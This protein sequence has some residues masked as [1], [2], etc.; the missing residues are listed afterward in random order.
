MYLNCHT[1]FS[2]RYG[3]MSP[4]ELAEQAVG[5]GAEALALTD[6][7]NTSAA[8]EFIRRCRSA[9]VKPV[10]GVEFRYRSRLNFIGLARNREGFRELNEYLSR[11]T[12]TPEL[13]PFGEHD[14][15]NC[16]VVYPFEET[17]I[18]PGR[19][20]D[21]EFVGVRPHEVNRLF[22]SPLRKYPGKLVALAP[23]VFQDERHHHLHKLLAAID[24]NCVFHKLDDRLTAHENDHFMT[25]AR[26]KEY[27]AVYPFLLTNARRLLDDCLIDLDLDS[28]KNKTTFTGSCADDRLLLEKLAAS[29]ARSRYGENRDDASRR[30]AHELQIIDKL[31]FTAYFLIAWDIVRYARSKGYRHVGRGSGGNSIVAYC[32]RITDV[33]PLDLDLYFERFINEFR[34]SPP[35]FDI[36]FSYDQRDDVLNYIFEKYGRER[37]A[38]LATYSTFRGRSIVRELGKV[39]G[40]PKEDIDLIVKRPDLNG[41]HHGL[42]TEIYQYGNMMA[43]FPNY[44]SMHP[45]GILISDG[46]VNNYSSQKQMPDGFPIVHFDMHEAEAIG[47][48]KLDI[49]SQRGLGHVKETVDIVEE[50]RGV[51]IDVDRV[52]DFKRDPRVN[53][54]LKKAKTAGCFYIESPA[55]RQLLSKLGCSDYKTLA[56]ASSVIRPGVAQSGMMQEYI[57]RFRG[58]P[59]KYIH[60]SF[61]THLGET[62]GVMVYQEDVIK[63][64]HHFAGLGLAESDVL[65]RMMSGKRNAGDRFDKLKAKYFENCRKKGRDPSVAKEVWRQIESF[66]GYSFCKAHSASYAVESYQSLFLKTYYPLEFITAVINNEG[67]FYRREI[68]VHEA[69][70]SGA[71]VHLPCV[72]HSRYKARLTGNDLYLGFCSIEGLEYKLAWQIVI[73]R[74]RNGEYTGLQNFVRRLQVT[75]EQLALLIRVGALRFMGKS[76]QQLLW[77]KN[78]YLQTEVKRPVHHG[79]FDEDDEQQSIEPFEIDP[80]QDAMDEIE[81]IGFP[82]T[83]SPFDLLKTKFRGEIMARE[84]T[85]HE[86]ETVRMV[87]YYVCE[88]DVRT[89]RRQRMAFGCWID[90]EGE[91]FDT[92]HFPDILNRDRFQG[93]GCYLIKGKVVLDFDFPQLEVERMAKLPIM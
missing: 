93:V 58:K 43:D 61:K 24:Q 46:P 40:L 14:F 38:F 18:K 19:L 35:D 74:E 45:G 70:K 53:H 10:C 63:I 73:E 51:R 86:G 5:V 4:A 26:L 3:T 12:L 49:L 17:P 32:L 13:Q 27:Y 28:L 84:M 60:E 90:A 16:Y 47:Y 80:Q 7:N 67:G 91:Y 23:V 59:F 83:I 52:E 1:Y 31:G 66:A 88:K 37:T 50:N 2:F 30:V 8:F 42:A 41:R 20:K 72:N 44:L 81:L 34:T 78:F 65:R 82:V 36:D 39:Y 64:A 56:A 89:V 11:H 33:E 75:P 21:Y 85:G 22:T 29:G 62:F 68:Y 25:R 87:G 69:R 9:G 79:L 57:S 48:F 15:K 55:M 71:N 92:V 54:L 77:E 6:I 76:K